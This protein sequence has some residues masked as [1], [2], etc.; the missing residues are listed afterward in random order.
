MT[1]VMFRKRDESFYSTDLRRKRA[2]DQIVG[3]APAPPKSCDARRWQSH[4]SRAT[5]ETTMVPH[6]HLVRAGLIV[7]GALIAF[8]VVRALLVPKS[9]GQY[10]HFR[11]DNLAEQMAPPS[12]YGPPDVCASCHAK[13]FDT[14]SKG[15]H[16]SVPCQTCHGPV[17]GHVQDDGMK[18]M[19]VNRSFT[20]CARCHQKLEARPTQF[21]QITIQ[22]HLGRVRLT[23]EGNEGVCLTCHNPHRP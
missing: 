19:I 8:F 14:K 9:F 5:R 21:P 2:I 16:A 7:V 13:I 6:R 4:C 12:Q 20:L 1:A 17:S 11:G 22:E 23:T 15:R 18:P 10:G 3:S